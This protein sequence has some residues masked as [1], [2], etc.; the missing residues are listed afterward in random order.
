[1]DTQQ[2]GVRSFGDGTAFLSK[3]KKEGRKLLLIFGK[4][5]SFFKEQRR[6]RNKARKEEIKQAF[7]KMN[8][9]VLKQD[10]RTQITVNRN[11]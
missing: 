7:L 4:S 5:N 2:S 10:R 1:M 3:S 6:L 8:E 9:E 11:I